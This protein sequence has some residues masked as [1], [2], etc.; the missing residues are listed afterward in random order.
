MSYT[1]I[2]IDASFWGHR[3][4]HTMPKGTEKTPLFSIEQHRIRFLKKI[5]TELSF[6]LR[7]FDSF[8][9]KDVIFCLDSKS[10]RKQYAL[11]WI[12]ENKEFLQID[13]FSEDIAY[14]G[15]READKTIDWTAY[16]K[17]QDEFFAGMSKVGIKTLKISRAEADDIIAVL[18]HEMNNK[19]ENV[20][21][22][23]S[24]KDMI[25]TVKLNKLTNA[26]T[27]LYNPIKSNKCLYIPANLPRTWGQNDDIWDLKIQS[28][29][30]ITWCQN[31]NI[32]VEYTVA[33]K[34]FYYKIIKGDDGDNVP[35]LIP[36][37][38]KVNIENIINSF[39]D[40]ANV[41]KLS[42][43]YDTFYYWLI[44]QKSVLQ[45]INSIDLQ[46][47][48]CR[49]MYNIKM[50]RLDYNNIPTEIINDIIESWKLIDHIK[51]NKKVFNLHSMLQNW[52]IS[53]E[54]N[55][56]KG[57]SNIDKLITDLELKSKPVTKKLL[58]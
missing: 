10:W 43:N 27:C 30:P 18:S 33:I 49:Y 6:M 11:D 2:V 12:N 8:N 7:Q 3:S 1:N 32:N 16:Y 15:K 20:I 31:N 14:K 26:W 51:L 35:K 13:G 34:F 47:F 24:D 54:P 57:V 44:K 4:V 28:I 19:G 58:I 36:G 40:Y 46:F 45:K 55:P 38:G 25:Q 52:G 56:T 39:F 9:L 53:D 41:N 5:I 23:T 37:F 17:I 22:V 42:L 50:M 29:N 48:R 21:I